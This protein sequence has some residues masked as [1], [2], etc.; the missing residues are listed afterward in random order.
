MTPENFADR[1]RAREQL[2]GYWIVTDNQPAAERIAGIGYDYVAVDG[3]HG[4]LDYRAWLTTMTAV[5]A[6]GSSAGIVRVPAIDPAWIG[7]ALDTGARGVIVPLVNTADEAALAVRACRYPP[8]GVRSF[9]PFR[10]SLRIGPTPADA[11]AAVVCLAMI[12]TPDGLRNVDDICATPGLDGLYVGPADLTLAVGGRYPG[13][14]A[15]RPAFDE[16]V[17]RILTAAHK[18][19]IACAM[20]CPDGET[21]A[22]MLA[23]G[24]T[25]TTISNDL[26]HLEQAATA[27][28]KTART[29]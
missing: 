12:E 14:Q 16:A 4:L 8:D 5:D 6:R 15:V 26:A 21:A 9:G 3:Q 19:G 18:S 13:D 1:V 29:P 23:R 28:L 2:V 24:F 7:K 10:S 11:N 20:H 27:H 17:D 25:M 22:R